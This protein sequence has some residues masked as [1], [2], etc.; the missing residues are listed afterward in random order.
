MKKSSTKLFLAAEYLTPIFASCSK[1]DD[2][3]N[4]KN[5]PTSVELAIAAC[6]GP[7]MFENGGFKLISLKYQR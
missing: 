5:M 6:V 7:A 1:T 2:N 4:Y 3:Y